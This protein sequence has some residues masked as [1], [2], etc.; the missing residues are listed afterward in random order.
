MPKSNAPNKPKNNKRVAIT[1]KCPKCNRRFTPSRALRKELNNLKKAKVKCHQCGGTSSHPK[2]KPNQHAGPISNAPNHG[3]NSQSV[4]QTK[5]KL[6]AGAK[7][8]SRGTIIPLN[9]RMNAERFFLMQTLNP[10]ATMG[11]RTIKLKADDTQ[12]PTVGYNFNSVFTVALNG[13]SGEDMSFKIKFLPSPV[14]VAQ[15]YSRLPITVHGH[16]AFTIPDGEGFLTSV[17]GSK[18]GQLGD[19]DEQFTFT[20]KLD[21]SKYRCIGYSAGSMW[22]GREIDKS[23]VVYAARMNEETRLA[24][25][26]PTAK[27]DSI[28]GRAF[29]EQSFSGM[30]KEPV[31]DWTFT[32]P[33]Q[34]AVEEPNFQP[35]HHTIKYNDSCVAYPLEH[36]PYEV[37]PSDPPNLLPVSTDNDP[38]RIIQRVFD[39]VISNGYLDNQLLAFN[40]QW[41][42]LAQNGREYSFNHA[43]TISYTFT[44]MV[45]PNSPESINVRTGEITLQPGTSPMRFVPGSFVNDVLFGPLIQA[46]TDNFIEGRLH[47]VSIDLLSSIRLQSR[48]VQYHKPQPT[49]RNIISQQLA[50][51]TDYL[52]LDDTW[53]APVADYRF[54]PISGDFVADVMMQ[55]VHV[56]NYEL[57]VSDTSIINNFTTAQASNSKDDVI[58]SKSIRLQKIMRGMPPMITF[59][60][61][62]VGQ[63]AQ[64]EL[65]SRGIVGDIA[66]LLGPIASTLFP[67]F[68]PLIGLGQSLANQF[69]SLGII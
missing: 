4:R 39:R 61:G 66:N 42:I 44:T 23:G 38:S 11:S 28:Y 47:T 3:T 25:F 27:Q 20:P 34:A 68:A 52:F 17:I 49:S 30:H 54:A 53:A 18:I 67:Q 21:W 59:D 45:L 41:N 69:D 64:T 22:V 5:K 56:T 13:S 31:Y 43:L 65:A 55:F 29:Q 16:R 6:M 15:I 1:W 7:A 24:D 10:K 19:I 48:N 63:T 51:E 58:D 50:D 40:R 2:Y 60:S 14:I 26:D 57:I 35:S 36:G 32:D 37:G 8:A 62:C 46:L 12:L 33:N 9:T